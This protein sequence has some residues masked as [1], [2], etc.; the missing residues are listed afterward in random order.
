[1]FLAEWGLWQLSLSPST[2]NGNSC[3]CRAPRRRL[4]GLQFVFHFHLPFGSN[5]PDSCLCAASRVTISQTL[6]W[7]ESLFLRWAGKTPSR[8]FNYQ[9]KSSVRGATAKL[10]YADA[11]LKMIWMKCASFASFRLKAFPTCWPAVDTS[12][13]TSNPRCDTSHLSPLQFAAAIL[14]FIYSHLRI[15]ADGRGQKT[16]SLTCYLWFTI[17]IPRE[18]QRR[19]S[20]LFDLNIIIKYEHWNVLLLSAW[21]WAT[22]GRCSCCGV[23][24]P[25]FWL[26]L[27][28]WSIGTPSA[29]P[30]RPE[31]NASCAAASLRHPSCCWQVVSAEIHSFVI[32]CWFI[33]LCV[34]LH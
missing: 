2:R 27:C 28:D 31:F 7:T 1:M 16:E 8:C 25:E 33:A 26:L 17:L 14:G 30:H 21:L 20:S 18:L 3:G 15:V 10:L 5:L 11:G 22:A 29:P 19:R 13:G 9:N 32:C 6:F 4:C 23:M 12:E 34:L 24:L